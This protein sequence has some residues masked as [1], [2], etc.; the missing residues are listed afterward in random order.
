MAS[1]EAD[2]LSPPGL[3]PGERLSFVAQPWLV[4][5]CRS[6]LVTDHAAQIPVRE[7]GVDLVDQDRLVI[8]RPVR[9]AEIRQEP[10]IADGEP[11]AERDGERVVGPRVEAGQ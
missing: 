7:R 11:D 8:R 1:E 10:A 3:T 9:V 6:E 5:R 2:L 4:T